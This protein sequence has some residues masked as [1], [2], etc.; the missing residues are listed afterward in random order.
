MDASCSEG[1]D[2]EARASNEN[3]AL[4]FAAKMR[5]VRDGARLAIVV[6]VVVPVV[7]LV[8]GL[9]V[10][11][12]ACVAIAAEPTVIL[13]S[14]DGT[15]PAAVRALPAFQRVA[16]GG[17][18][19]DRLV[20]AFPSNTFPNHAT[21]A[22]GVS[23]DR[24]GIV[25]NSFVDPVRGRYHYAADPTWLEAEPIWSLAARAGIVSASYFWVGSEGN[26]SSGLGPRHW[27]KFDTKVPEPAKVEQ[28][29]AWLDLADPAERPRLV[30]SWF[31]GGD[32]AAHRHG[33]D[34]AEVAAVL[35][36]QD[37]ALAALIDGLVARDLLATTTLLLVSDHGMTETER[38]ADLADALVDEKVFAEVIG[39]GGF[40][41]VSCLG[42]DDCA[43]R[44]L[45]VARGLGL[46]AWRPGAAPAA[47]ATAN[48]RFGDVVVVAP[49]GTS[50]AA[51]TGWAWLMGRVGL[52]RFAIRGI[53][54]HR[55]ELPEMGALFAAIGRG[56]APGARPGTVRAVDVA[57]T[58]LALLGLPIPPSM[59]G[60]PISLEAGAAR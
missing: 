60:R 44:V 39:G 16:T 11:P 8:V 55:P 36:Q 47:Y 58:V 9:V 29:L 31:H 49:L 26:W 54:G 34:S 51:Q 52:E 23:P 2:R 24:H 7:V 32:G 41:Q 25:N 45:E 21:F 20:P 18:W 19:A 30:T 53:H 28:I 35:A 3:A 40:A 17:A 48:P 57:P 1:A 12:S 33:P 14:F 50:I 38:T 27:K 4:R 56:V 5:A 6:P 10:V 42:A 43:P 13:I 15:P 37:A 59:E 46:E 22:T